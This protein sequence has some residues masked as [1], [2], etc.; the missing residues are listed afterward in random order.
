MRVNDIMSV[1]VHTIGAEEPATAAW[2]TMRF[3]RTRH[4]VVVNHEGRVVGVISASDL[5]GKRGDVVRAQQ[6]VSDLMTEKV[7]AVRP[8]TTIREAANLMRGHSVNCLPV[9][10]SRDRLAGIVT[11]VD[12]LEL[13][14]RGT[15]RPMTA[16]PRAVLKNRG[17]LPRQATAKNRPGRA[18]R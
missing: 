14:G 17:V 11:V 16:T 12:L 1:P 3:C 7:I 5:G 6:R 9:F 4:L 8:E 15:E 10:N 13:V 18:A 2:E